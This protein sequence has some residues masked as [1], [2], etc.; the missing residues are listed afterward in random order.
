MRTDRFLAGSLFLSALITSPC[1]AESSAGQ[2]TQLVERAL[3]AELRAAQETSHPMCYD[4]RRSSPRMTTTKEI[5]E[6]KDG[7]VARLVALNNRPLTPAEEQREEARLDGLLSEPARQRHRKQSEDADTERVLK[8]LRALPNAFLYRPE[9]TV[10]GPAGT[11]E[12]FS[13]RP[14]PRF[15][16]PNLET[17]ALT[18]LEGELWIDA[19]QGRVTRLEGHLVQDVN[20]GWGILGQLNK[21]GWIRIEQANVGGGQWRITRFQLEM[22][23]R[24]VLKNKVFRSDQWQTGFRPVPAGLT[25]EQAIR[26]LRAGPSQTAAQNH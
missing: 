1:W 6:T 20:F 18:E 4:L 3:A 19:A 10:P 24:V 7:S 15:D 17:V 14:N 16:P 23:G 11:L 2:A 22:T 21:G 26:M 25:Y 9:G 13:F 12:H 8:I 5:C